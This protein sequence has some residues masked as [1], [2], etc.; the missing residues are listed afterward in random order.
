M[1]DGRQFI[2]GS[3][4]EGTQK[5]GFIR[6]GSASRRVKLESFL[7]MNE[8]RVASFLADFLSNIR[9]YGQFVSAVSQ[10]HE[11]TTERMTVDRAPDF[12][13][14]SCPKERG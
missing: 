2:A 6:F 9:F 3:K 7:Q 5:A 14:T 1:G 12:H 10:S 8:Y 11:R 4:G 13:E